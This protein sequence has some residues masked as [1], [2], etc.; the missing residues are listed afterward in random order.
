MLPEKVVYRDHGGFLVV[1][2]KRG[3]SSSARRD[4]LGFSARLLERP[5][6]DLRLLDRDDR[7]RDAVDQQDGNLDVSACAAGETSRRRAS[8]LS[9][10][11]IALSQ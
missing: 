10:S 11:P 8:S 2:R 1:G 3:C 6:H 7:V 5:L 9:E 4:E